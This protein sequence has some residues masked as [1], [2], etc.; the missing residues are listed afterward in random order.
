MIRTERLTLDA[1]K[2]A[3]KAALIEMFR[4]EKVNRTYMIPDL[5]DEA[6]DKLFDR[7]CALSNSPDRIVLGV[8]LDGKIVGLI[9]DT[10]IDNGAVELGWVISPLY[11]NRGYA[12]EAVRALIKKLFD[13]G[14]SEV[15]AGA[16]DEN[17][18]SIRVMEKCSMMRTDKEET[19]DYRG[20]SHRCLYYSIK[21]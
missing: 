11:Q 8:Y 3:D 16:F 19:I 13:D 20:A 4:D 17:P 6:A 7:L 9:N 15:V 5:D 21:K 2:G 18:A 10:G 14:F 12:T 1:L